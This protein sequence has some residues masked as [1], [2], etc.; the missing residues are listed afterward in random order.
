ME[1]HF[2]KERKKKQNKMIHQGATWRPLVLSSEVSTTQSDSRGSQSR[3]KRR[4]K[5]WRWGWSEE[6]GGIVA[7]VEGRVLGLAL[8]MCAQSVIPDFAT[9]WTVAHQAPLSMEFSR[10]EYWSGLLRPPPGDLP[11]PGNEL[12]SPALGSLP[13][14]HLESP[15]KHGSR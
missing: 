10:Q 11:D 14:Y 15:F 5:R 12:L 13:W 4:N 3:V 8:S 6:K 7:E 1:V 9:P 2:K